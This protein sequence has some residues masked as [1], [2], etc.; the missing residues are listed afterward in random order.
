MK[1]IEHLT[2]TNLDEQLRRTIGTWI[3]QRGMSARRFGVEA[4]GDPGFVGSLMRGRSAR[5]D[6]A[7]RVLRFMG[8]PLLGPAFRRE[9]EVFLAVTGTKP[10]ILGA[11]A[12]GDSSF[13]ARLRRGSASQLGTIERLRAWM[14]AHA[15]GEEIRAI[16]ADNDY[17]GTMRPGPFT[18]V[19]TAGAVIAPE[20]ETC[21]NEKDK[22]YL[23]T[24]EAADWL[25]LSPR[26][27]DR[28]RVSGDGP[29]FHRFGARVR[30]LLADLEAWAAARRRTSTSDDGRRVA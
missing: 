10:T 7:D 28:Y 21:M 12:L 16:R 17:A 6:T 25:G 14:A 30:Y 9:V 23:S 13:V 24:R 29:P 20:G 27:L 4:L 8:E 18:E 26:T 2:G 22:H 11:E 15:S 3:A 1:K 19:P 5:L